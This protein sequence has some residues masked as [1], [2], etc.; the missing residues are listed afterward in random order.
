MPTIQEFAQSIKQKYPQYQHVDDKELAIKMLEKYPEY[1]GKVFDTDP[2]SQLNLTPQEK[3]EGMWEAIKQGGRNIVEGIKDT[4]NKLSEVVNAPLQSNSSGEAAANQFVKTV[5]AGTTIAKGIVSPIFEAGVS[6]PMRVAGE[7]I[8][9]VTGIDINEAVSQGMQKLVQR[10]MNTDVAKKTMEGWKQLNDTNPQAAMALSAALD[11]GEL[12]SYAIGSKGVSKASN[13]VSTGAGKVGKMAGNAGSKV[14]GAV[15]KGS[16]YVAGQAYGLKPETVQTIIK[17]PKYFTAREMSKIDRESI[18]NRVKGAVEGRMEGLSETGKAYDAI[19]KSGERVIFK[20]NPVDDV[21]RKY[22]VTVQNGKLLTTAESVPL[23]TGDINAIEGFMKQYGQ[24]ELSANGFLNA[25]KALSNMA[26]YDAS[27]TDM[28][29]KIAREIRRAY[30][31]EGKK[32]L[33]GL[34]K[35]DAQYAPEIQLL[36]KVKKVIFNNDGSLKDNAVSAIANLTGKGKEQVLKRMEK[37]IPGIA[38]DVN[39][40]KA[41]EDISYAEG[42]KVGTYMRAGLGVGTGALAGGPVGAVVGAIIT[43]P[44]VGVSLLRSYGK[45]KNISSNFINGMI[46]KMKSGKKLV[47]KELDTMNGAVDTAAKKMASRAKNITPGLTIKDKDSIVKRIFTE[48]IA[49]EDIPYTAGGRGIKP[50]LNTVTKEGMNQK[51]VTGR[52]NDV[53]QKL[54]NEGFVDEAKYYADQMSG[55]KFADYFDFTKQNA[56]VFSQIMGKSGERV[57]TIA[58]SQ[59]LKEGVKRIKSLKPDEVN[60]FSDFTDLV[61]GSYRPGTKEADALRKDVVASM[62]RIGMKIPQTDQGIAN[63]VSRVLE[64]LNFKRTG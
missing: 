1:R 2:N 30:D 9:D 5:K 21:L 11:I 55:K 8:Q 22:G 40:L 34:A 62:K 45:F 10:G 14:K 60:S 51:M 25:R 19:R 24:Q 23:S 43:S 12:A 32:A 17:N 16:E 63:A 13:V 29:D 46:N 52:I 54:K 6:T 33:T 15:G 3:P 41:I 53:V 47:G 7:G 26:R 64:K 61:A 50:V 27:K 18:F 39:I 35:L 20:N 4:G 38:E 57:K 31:A 44:R 42:Q 48:S 37:I 36:G 56:N 59:P 58:K 49:N 28:A